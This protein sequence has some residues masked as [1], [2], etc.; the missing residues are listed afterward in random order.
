MSAEEEK[1][2]TIP[3]FRTPHLHRY[4]FF[5][6]GFQG[7]ILCRAPAEYRKINRMCSLQV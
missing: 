3:I 1:L 6:T 7:T 4:L 2:T 5:L